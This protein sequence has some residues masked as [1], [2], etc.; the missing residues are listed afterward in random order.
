MQLPLESRLGA[1]RGLGGF[2]ARQKIGLRGHVERATQ[3]FVAG[4]RGIAR[5]ATNL[6]QRGLRVTARAT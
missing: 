2:G 5:L 1:T 6:V 3:Q 4:E